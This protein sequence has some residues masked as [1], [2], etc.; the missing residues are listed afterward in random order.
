PIFMDGERRRL[1]CPPIYRKVDGGGRVYVGL[2]YAGKEIVAHLTYPR[3]DDWG[4]YEQIGQP[5]LPRY[6]PQMS[7]KIKIA[8]LAQ[9][10]ALGAVK[11][12]DEDGNM[13]LSRCFEGWGL[14]PPTDDDVKALFTIL[15]E[16]LEIELFQSEAIP[17]DEPCND[18]DDIQFEERTGAYVQQWIDDQ[19]RG[20]PRMNKRRLLRLVCL[21]RALIRQAVKGEKDLTEFQKRWG[22]TG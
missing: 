7:E 20:Y 12:G 4:R 11:N 15:D 18:L 2:A 19:F 10:L 22:C 17:T 16:L 13:G 14:S 21:V 3:G 6:D 8:D 5:S 1:I 9:Q